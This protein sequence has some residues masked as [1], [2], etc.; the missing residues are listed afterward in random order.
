MTCRSSIIIDNFLPQNIFDD[1]SSK[2]INVSNYKNNE[3]AELKDEL[4]IE[5]YTAVFNR[6]KELDIFQIHFEESIKLFGYNQFRPSDYG[7]GNTY[8]PHIDNGG[9]V[10]YVHPDWDESWGGQ[11]KITKAVE[12][13]YRT[14]IFAKP[15]RFIW[16][17]PSTFHDVTSTSEYIPHARVANIAF[18]GGEMYKDPVG[19]DFINIFTSN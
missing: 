13:K 12:E 14:G 16:I 18:L 10:F 8:G 19:T 7:H 1:I 17:D 5:C 3:F 9:Y 11:L 2:V 4:W 6:L 15:N